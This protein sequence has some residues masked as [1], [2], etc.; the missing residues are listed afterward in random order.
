MRRKIQKQK[1]RVQIVDK[2]KYNQIKYG[3]YLVLDIN[4]R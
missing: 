4:T 1:H 2:E 3:D